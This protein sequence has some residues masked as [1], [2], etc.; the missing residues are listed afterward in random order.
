[1]TAKISTPFFDKV[2]TKEGRRR[3][4]P[5]AHTPYISAQYLLM[6]LTASQILEADDDRP[7]SPPQSGG[8]NAT[9][10]YSTGET[11]YG[12]WENNKREGVG[13]YLYVT[14]DAYWGHWHR[15]LKSGYGV[16]IK[17]N[18]IESYAG[19]W[20]NNSRNGRGCLIQKNGTRFIGS[21][22]E[23]LRHGPGVSVR[24]SGQILGE[25]WRHGQLAHRQYILLCND[26]DLVMNGR[27][28]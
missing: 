5:S 26:S 1:M 19:E 9:Y 17:A 24:R 12:G 3:K 13:T 21:F 8:L 7:E 14:G 6:G 2:D 20:M 23:D 28:V 15:N 27:N 25:L 22:R 10:S 4:F 11:Y 18:H 16:Y